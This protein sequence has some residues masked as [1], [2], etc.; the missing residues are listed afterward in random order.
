MK[1]GMPPTRMRRTANSVKQWAEGHVKRLFGPLAVLL[2]PAAV[3]FVLLFLLPFLWLG[4]LSFEEFEPGVN[5]YVALFTSAGGARVFG[6][7]FYFATI[8]TVV[9]L[10][11]AYVLAYVICYGQNLHRALLVVLVYSLWVSA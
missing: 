1:L 10:L 3:V 2:V 7:T 4:A 9:S 5:N 11:G 8:S 6:S